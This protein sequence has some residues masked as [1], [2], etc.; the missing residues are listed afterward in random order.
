MLVS[1]FFLHLYYLCYLYPELKN[2]AA[3]AVSQ[4]WNLN[5]PS[6]FCFHLFLM[7]WQKQMKESCNTEAELIKQTHGS[8]IP[9]RSV[10]VYQLKNASYV[11]FPVCAAQYWQS[12]PVQCMT[13]EG[14]A[15][16]GVISI[17]PLWPNCRWRKYKDLFGV[18]SSLIRENIMSFCVKRASNLC[19]IWR[20]RWEKPC[21]ES[22]MV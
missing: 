21:R 9:T 11:S 22:F 7:Q 19:F 15:P 20:W 16:K 18:W 6:F 5:L 14:T 2:H 8:L 1:G 12:G 10:A 17:R 4:K 3:F 13:N